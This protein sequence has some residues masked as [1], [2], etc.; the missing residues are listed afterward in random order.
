VVVKRLADAP[1][2]T[3]PIVLARRAGP[4]SALVRAFLDVVRQST[5]A[6]KDVPRLTA[7]RK[8]S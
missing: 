1:A 5:G 2:L 7:R 3:V 4:A 6:P 8:K